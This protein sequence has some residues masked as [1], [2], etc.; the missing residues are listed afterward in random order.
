MRRHPLALLLLL[1]LPVP[2][3]AQDGPHVELRRLH[4]HVAWL[5]APAR[6]GRGSWT[7][8]KATADYVAAAFRAAGLAPLPGRDSMF[9]D[10]PGDPSAGKDAEPALRNVVAWLPGAHGA[11][12]E[13][14]ILSA[15]YDH[16]GQRAT[17]T[18]SE[19]GTITRT[20]V[21]YPGADD[22]ASGV[23][24]LL[25]IARVLGA[26]HAAAPKSFPRALVFVA[27]DLEERETKG[28]RFYVKA[29]CLP[30]ER[31]AAFLTMDML[32]R[33][34]ADLAPGSLFVMGTENSAALDDDVR[35]VGD[36]KGGR[37]TTVGIDFQPG[38]S[39]YVP[40]RAAKVPYVFITSGA[41][42][43][44][45]A[46]G[47]VPA[48]LDEAQL[49][50]RT[51]WVRDLTWRVLTD[52]RRPVWRDGV[53]PQVGEMKDLRT[54]IRGVQ[55]HLADVP[56]VPP[57]AAVMVGNYGTYL[58][59]ILSDGKVTPRERESARTAALNLFKLA[60]HL[61]QR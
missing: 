40:F 3:L 36:P 21:T 52:E 57:L 7:Q 1:F 39:D 42:A 32:G 50:A 18:R 45:H 56:G 35:A 11:D 27:F 59:G 46:P 6:Q 17:E 22:N 13:H 25:E 16:L 2:A 47:D 19:D 10:A 26:R 53:P 28:S 49:L 61:A 23:A 60:A 43:D 9:V 33:S 20:T 34:I 41:C 48:R 44:Y 30:L 24:A 38:Y 58:D 4:D 37:R 15:H 5:A 55:G 14:V 29:P 54:L 51:R 8:R 31:C 12:G